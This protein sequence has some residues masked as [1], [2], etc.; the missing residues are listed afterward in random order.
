[1]CELDPFPRIWLNLLQL[2]PAAFLC[3]YS[4]CTERFLYVVSATSTHVC[5][6]QQYYNVSLTTETEYQLAKLLEYC[7]NLY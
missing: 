7:L 3:I 5:F 2:F 1:M 4:T 6:E